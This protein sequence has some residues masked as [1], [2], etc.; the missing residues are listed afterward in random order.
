MDA[1]CVPKS[2]SS[3]LYLCLGKFVYLNSSRKSIPP[4]ASETSPGRIL[5]PLPPPSSAAFE[6]EIC[7]ALKGL[8]LMRPKPPADAPATE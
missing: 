4:V 6:A 8:V 1:L 3:L 7:G 5:S 2:F